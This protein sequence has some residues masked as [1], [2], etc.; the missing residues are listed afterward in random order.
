MAADHSKQSVACRSPCDA[1]NVTIV[2]S[3]MSSYLTQLW[4]NITYPFKHIKKLKVQ[5][6]LY[7]NTIHGTKKMWSYIAGGLK[8][9]GY[10]TQKNCPLGPNQVVL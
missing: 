10:L 4:Y 3:K 9:K 1:R 5:W 7:F 8:I 6:S 2:V